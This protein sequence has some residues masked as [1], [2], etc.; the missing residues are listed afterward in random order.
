MSKICIH[1]KNNRDLWIS[2][3]E[4]RIQ[5]M[6]PTDHFHPSAGLFGILRK[7]VI[8]P[9]PFVNFVIPSLIWTSWD[10]AEVSVW[11]VGAPKHLWLSIFVRAIHGFHNGS[12]DHSHRSFAG[13]NSIVGNH[14]QLLVEKIRVMNSHDRIC[15]DHFEG[16]IWIFELL[17]LMNIKPVWKLKI[18]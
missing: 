10:T 8:W 6:I 4:R 5:T 13:W 18:Y 3:L 11:F 16:D 9:L 17:T 14:E 2:F 15:S 7:S 12:I 1:T